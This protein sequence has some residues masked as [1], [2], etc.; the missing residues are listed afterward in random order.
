MTTHQEQAEAQDEG[1]DLRTRVLVRAWKDPEFR[2][3]V[4]NDPGA[5][6]KQL[7]VSL[8][9][10]IKLAV[11][12]DDPETYNLILREPPSGPPS[13]VEAADV[14][15]YAVAASQGSIC[16]ITAECF[17]PNSITGACGLFCPGSFTAEMPSQPAVR[18]GPTG[19]TKLPGST[20]DPRG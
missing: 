19:S 8:P 6:V 14:T 16:T 4:R 7:G 9:D 3:L 13:T 11:L 2:A 20:L 17:C 12:E 5:A 10:N 15:G 18:L 1:Q